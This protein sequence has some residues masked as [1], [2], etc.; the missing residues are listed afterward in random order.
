MT[1]TSVTGTVWFASTT[2]YKTEQLAQT[3]VPAQLRARLSNCSQAHSRARQISQR[4]ST[5]GFSAAS[6]SINGGMSKSSASKDCKSSSGGNVSGGSACVDEAA[7]A[8]SPTVALDDDEAANASA[9]SVALDDDEATIAPS[10]PTV[11]LDDEALTAVPLLVGRAFG[12]GFGIFLI[13][14]CTGSG[15]LGGG[16]G[17]GPPSGLSIGG[18]RKP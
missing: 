10:E 5:T 18:L 7:N 15:G 9:P 17:G 16:L 12:F 8:S 11:A 2:A 6:T 1:E 14:G 13:F 3:V 4:N